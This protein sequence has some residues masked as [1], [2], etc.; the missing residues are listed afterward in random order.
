MS[1]ISPH[2]RNDQAKGLDPTVKVYLDE[3]FLRHLKNV[4]I[5]HPRLL[6]V[7]A[8]G[9]GVG[10]STLAA[11]IGEELQALVLENDQIKEC[12]LEFDPSL[13]TDRD[14]MNQLAWQYSMDLYNRL[15]EVTANGFVVRDGVIH[16][17]YDRILPVFEKQGYA[18]FIISYDLSRQKRL[19]LIRTRGD[20]QTV[21]AERLIA[22]M[23][24]HDILMK[25]FHD[26]YQPD[27]I[28]HDDD[29]FDYDPVIAA[30][31]ARLG[32]LS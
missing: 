26:H 14:R 22:I 13:K 23:E 2:Y 27:I 10:K 28:L 20:K 9:N 5:P 12:L 8:G 19:E 21:S 24:D 6:V 11:R 32:Q 30:L 3:H 1:S 25:R 17:Y 31:R 29:L 16:W 18:V 7:F 4:D 15:P